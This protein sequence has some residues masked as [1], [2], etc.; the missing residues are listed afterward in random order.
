M[1]ANYLKLAF[2][3][4]LR[5]RFFTF[6]S[7]F[8]ISLTLLVLLV[9][10]ALLDQVLAPARP[11]SRLGRTLFVERA[12]LV[13]ENSRS[14]G[15]P[16]Y[17]LLDR[18]AR[19]LPGVERAAF[20][21]NPRAVTSYLRGEKIVSQLRN[22]DPV[23]WEILDFTFL[24][25]GPL[26]ASDERGTEP[27]AVI[28]DATR[29]RFFG[30]GATALGRLVEADGQRYRVTG[31]VRAPARTRLAAYAD[32][33][34]PLA[35]EPTD[36]WRRQ[37]RG[38]FNAMLL[39]RDRRAFPGIQA[40]FRARVA[41]LDVSESRHFTRASSSAVTRFEVIATE[42][43]GDRGSSVTNGAPGSAPPPSP[44]RRAV[45]IMVAL[46]L[47]FMLLPAIN[48]V[49]INISRIFERASEIG[50]RK[51]FGASSRQLVGQF[52]VENIVLCLIGGALGLV[53]TVGCLAW[54]TSTQAVPG[55]EFRINPSLFLY[56]LGLS[57]F[58]GVLSG[59]YPAWRM[60][61]LNPVSALKGGGA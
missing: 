36:S 27:V 14:T 3:V 26:T 13:G 39:A 53:G 35:A 30:P 32:I 58:F 12:T 9:V 44:A 54:L 46:A 33:W 34:L 19:D 38:S 20:Y 61:R 8:G 42:T 6:I 31:V 51:S 16:G 5:R 41:R 7:L 45:G 50:V 56:A 59:A 1:L 49:N 10:A 43:L 60:S 48:L 57:I 17:A 22:T 23:Y 37:L 28:S 25:G 24:E 55:A 40:E 47:G 21:T 11:E 4:L 18:C 52:V 15:P 29:R 2:K